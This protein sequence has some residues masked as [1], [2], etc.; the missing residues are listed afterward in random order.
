[1]TW[2]QVHSRHVSGN[3]SDHQ[4]QGSMQTYKLLLTHDCPE[5]GRS[6][7]RWCS[8]AY[9]A[10]QM[11]GRQVQGPSDTKLNHEHLFTSIS[12]WVDVAF[13]M[14]TTIISF[15]TTGG[16][17]IPMWTIFSLHIKSHIQ[18]HIKS[19][20]QVVWTGEAVNVSTPRVSLGNINPQYSHLL[21]TGVCWKKYKEGLI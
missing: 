20:V 15:H 4:R 5:K 17:S 21:S 9:I 13:S 7:E 6:N 3:N 14:W 11:G 16:C 19:Q 10:K 2:T 18:L 12:F 1:M 8:A